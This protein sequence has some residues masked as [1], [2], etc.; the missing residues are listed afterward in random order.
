MMAI[1]EGKL[2]EKERRRVNMVLSAKSCGLEEPFSEDLIE[3]SEYYVQRKPKL[4]EKAKPL[5]EIV[6]ER[7]NQTATK[8]S[9][10]EDEEVSREALLD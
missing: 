2:E 8:R 6:K 4:K 10:T 1:K 9:R 7:M 5:E 3:K